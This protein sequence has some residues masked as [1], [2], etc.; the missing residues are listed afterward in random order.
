MQWMDPRSRSPNCGKGRGGERNRS[1]NVVEVKAPPSS[2]ATPAGVVNVSQVAQDLVPQDV[3]RAQLSELLGEK[4]VDFLAAENA[5]LREELAAARAGGIER[6]DWSAKR[7]R[8]NQGSLKGPC[9]KTPES[10]RTLNGEK[11]AEV[12]FTPGGTEVPPGEPPMEEE[13][14]PLPRPRKWVVGRVGCVSAARAV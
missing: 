4:V 10:G 2:W 3:G 7:R 8:R 14:V 9:E 6:R 1:R 12:R 5:K 11:P 13:E